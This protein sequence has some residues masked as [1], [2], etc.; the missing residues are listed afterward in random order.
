MQAMIQLHSNIP[1]IILIIINLTEEDII[2][3]DQLHYWINF[4]GNRCARLKDKAH[5]IVIGSHADLLES[6]GVNPSQRMSLFLESIETQVV[7]RMICLKDYIDLLNCTKSRSDKMETLR[8]VLQESTND[9]RESGVMHFN[10]HC[11][12]VFLLHMFRGEDF[13]TLH[14]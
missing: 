7:K 11:F 13:V 10:S 1:P 8:N 5:L 2:I 9:L 6:Q 4:I 3:R 14:G 12:Y